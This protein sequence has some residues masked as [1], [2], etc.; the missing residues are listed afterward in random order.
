MNHLFSLGFL[1][2]TVLISPWLLL[3]LHCRPCQA[4]F[5]VTLYKYQDSQTALWRIP[6]HDRNR[7][8]PLYAVPPP[9]PPVEHVTSTLT[10]SVSIVM[11]DSLGTSMPVLVDADGLVS[12]ILVMILVAFNMTTD[13]KVF[14]MEQVSKVDIEVSKVG[15]KVDREVSQ[16]GSKMGTDVR[17]VG[18]KVDRE[19]S[20]LGYKMGTEVSKVERE[21][22]QLGSK[23][24][25]EVSKVEREVS[26]LG[27]KMDKD[28]SE[29]K[30]EMAQQGSKL[31]KDI[32]ELRSDMKVMDTK[33][34]TMRRTM[35]EMKLLMIELKNK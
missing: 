26:Q 35:D 6:S 30:A 33:I 32:T 34:D 7:A 1:F 5:G 10:S 11:S 9:L 23:M 31:N 19:V 27:Y 14:I 2:Q 16:L 25:T 15:Y 18:Y 8:V 22:S 24:S 28:K 29:I 17:E 13:I 3:L 4:A 21:V 12:L 20:Q